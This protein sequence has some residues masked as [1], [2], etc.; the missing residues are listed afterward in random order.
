MK[1]A[2]I[3]V[4]TKDIGGFNVACPV[5]EKLKDSNEL[6]IAAEG[7]SLAK[8][9]ESGYA[10]IE[11]EPDLES[12]KP[13]LVVCTAGSPIN[14][15]NKV[16]SRAKESGI[17]LMLLEDVWGVHR[18]IDAAP[19]Y[20]CTPDKMAKQMIT[21]NPKY[22][23]TSTFVTGSPAFDHLVRYSSMSVV[24]EREKLNLP[25]DKRIILFSGPGFA[26]D[27]L[28][29]MEA[30]EQ[31][32]AQS[33]VLLIS[34]LHPKLKI[35]DSEGWD[36][37]EEIISGAGSKAIL[38]PSADMDDLIFVSDF[39]ISTFSITLIK[40]VYLRKIPISFVSDGIRENMARE[41]NSIRFPLVESGCAY[42]AE[43]A[44]DIIDIINRRKHPVVPKNQE[45]GFNLDGR[46]ADRIV[47][48][49]M[50]ILG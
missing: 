24:K 34:R 9:K 17:L 32:L 38:R 18:R 23:Q 25:L 1:K 26:N 19:D 48:V 50:D 22:A 28:E 14:L 29:I 40:A 42:E 12:L 4:V 27:T 10:V 44:D 33:D 31:V 11:T 7:L 46:N 15:E 45:L 8:W 30:L 16:A 36:K 37:C 41:I 43:D 49:I 6:V 2:K 5:T 3:L 47:R 39:V 35:L 20:I 13:D 21:A